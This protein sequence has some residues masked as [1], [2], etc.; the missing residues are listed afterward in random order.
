MKPSIIKIRCRYKL[1]FGNAWQIVER[2]WYGGK[3]IFETYNYV[4]TK[5]AFSDL[6]KLPF[7]KSE[8]ELYKK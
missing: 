7:Y 3:V 1:G 2:R 8:E 5:E 6:L 4:L